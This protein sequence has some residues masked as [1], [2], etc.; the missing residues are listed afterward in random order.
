MASYR[1]G[2]VAD[3]L[4]TVHHGSQWMQRMARATVRIAIGCNTLAIHTASSPSCGKYSVD[5]RN[6]N[7]SVL[8]MYRIQL[9][10]VQHLCATS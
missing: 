2:D 6:E 1:V 5:G 4:C 9:A 10:V 7:P 8:T 3:H